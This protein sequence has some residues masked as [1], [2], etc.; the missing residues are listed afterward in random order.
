MAYDKASGTYVRAL[1]SDEG[2]GT[3]YQFFMEA[4]PKL[5][6]TKNNSLSRNNRIALI[7]KYREQVQIHKLIVLPAGLRDIRIDDTMLES[8]SINSIYMTIMSYA[9]AF[10]NDMCTNPLYNSVRFALQKKV[11]ELFEYLENVMAGGTGY[12]EKKFLARQ[13]AY[14]TR[15]VISSAT[16]TSESSDDPEFF[17]I[18]ETKIPLIQACGGGKPLVTHNMRKY[19]FAPIFSSSTEQVP[20]VNP[21]TLTTEYIHISEDEKNKF[22]T[23][24]GLSDIINLC[25][26]NSVMWSPITIV[27]IENNKKYP[28][29]MT[30]SITTPKGEDRVYLVKSVTELKAALEPRGLTYDPA[31]LRFMTYCEL[32]YISAYLALSDKTCTVTRYP[33]AGLASLVLTKQK[34]AST[35]P[36]RRV[37]LSMFSSSDR[38]DL[39]ELPHYPVINGALLKSLAIHPAYMDGLGADF[40]GDTATELPVLSD[41]AAEEGRA[42]IDSK[43]NVINDGGGLAIGSPTAMA[44]MTFYNLTLDPQ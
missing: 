17:K 11:V 33:I 12:L 15:N 18:D 8:D 24:D 28:L 38:D 41:D 34:I 2:A 20:V 10:P 27:N 1:E 6:F 40:D 25:Q 19:F 31:N 43:H 39:M 37:Y 5:T 32:L 16:M 4:F 35:E 29:I 14:G 21:E 9:R 26:N 3:G 22:T 36:S 23:S 7:E 44:K 13:V 42:Y 30:Y